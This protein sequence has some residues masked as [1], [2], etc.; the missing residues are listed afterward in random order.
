MDRRYMFAIIPGKQ[1]ILTQ[2]GIKINYEKTQN[3]ITRIK[4]Q[5][6]IQ[7]LEELNTFFY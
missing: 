7:N 1:I 2:K 3:Y 5:K 4:I 6:M